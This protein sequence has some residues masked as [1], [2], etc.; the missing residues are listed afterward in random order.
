MNYKTRG[1]LNLLIMYYNETAKFFTI[2]REKQ[3]CS[4]EWNKYKRNISQ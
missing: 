1:N 2:A 3:F 4:K